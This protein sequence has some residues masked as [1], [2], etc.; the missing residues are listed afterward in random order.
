YVG[1]HDADPLSEFRKL[2]RGGIGDSLIAPI[3]EHQIE[4]IGGQPPGNCQSDTT[5]PARDY[6][7]PTP[8]RHS[9]LLLGQ[10]VSAASAATPVA[11]FVVSSRLTPATPQRTTLAAQ[12][13]PPPNATSTM[14]APS[15]SIPDSS[16]S[17]MAMG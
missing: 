13:S 8:L 16:A 5:C 6:R 7:N 3:G 12:A 17:T 15:E 2:F 4:P 10:C 9:M 11:S 14:F 1:S